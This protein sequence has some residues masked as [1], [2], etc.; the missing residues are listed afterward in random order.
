MQSEN[1]LGWAWFSHPA[2]KKPGILCSCTL[3]ILNMIKTLNFAETPWGYRFI[4]IFI[5]AKFI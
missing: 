4:R 3:M 1:D 2:F 5:W